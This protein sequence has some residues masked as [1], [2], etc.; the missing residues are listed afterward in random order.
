MIKK[1]RKF[2][3]SQVAKGDKTILWAFSALIFIGAAIWLIVGILGFI[4]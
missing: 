4:N 3:A 2:M 1:I